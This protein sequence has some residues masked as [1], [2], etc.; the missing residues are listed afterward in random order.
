VKKIF[1]LVRG[2]IVWGWTDVHAALT[3]SFKRRGRRFLHMDSKGGVGEGEL[4]RARCNWRT[5]NP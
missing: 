4:D 5:E 3:L 1:D 2:G